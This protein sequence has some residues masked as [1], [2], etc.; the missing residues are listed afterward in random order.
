LNHF[1]IDYSFTDS[2]STFEPIKAKSECVFA[3][4]SKLWSGISNWNET[5][6]VEQN[7]ERIVPVFIL[8]T[9]FCI[10]LKLDGFLIQLPGS[11]YGMNT[12]VFINDTSFL[13]H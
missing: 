9:N 3:K 6:N 2:L 8:F 13:F 11:S 5:L 1:V 12:K 4:K 7:L 10:S